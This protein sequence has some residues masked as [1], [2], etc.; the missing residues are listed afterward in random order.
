MNL[1]Q[2]SLYAAVIALPSFPQ[3]SAPETKVDFDANTLPIVFDE[4]F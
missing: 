1:V 3:S 2:S 4:S